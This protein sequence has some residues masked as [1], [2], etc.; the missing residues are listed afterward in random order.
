MPV[1]RHKLD[2]NDLSKHH[3]RESNEEAKNTQL[4][5][6]SEIK[7]HQA[8]TAFINMCSHLFLEIL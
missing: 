4:L 3:S 8:F 7:G 2:A 1:I 6:T 5:P